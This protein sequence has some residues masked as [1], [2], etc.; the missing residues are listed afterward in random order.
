MLLL[1]LLLP[2]V[3]LERLK[4]WFEVDKVKGFGRNVISL[5][6]G[7]AQMLN[8]ELKEIKRKK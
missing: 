2:L 7:F 5:S 3:S 6:E 4:I 8:M 1:E